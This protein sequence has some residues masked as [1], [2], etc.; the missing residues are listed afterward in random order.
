MHATESWFRF[1]SAL[2]HGTLHVIVLQLGEEI[3][4]SLVLLNELLELGNVLLIELNL[5]LHILQ[6]GTVAFQ[7]KLASLL[8]PVGFGRLLLQSL[9]HVGRL[10]FVDLLHLTVLV[11]D[12]RDVLLLQNALLTEPFLVLQRLADVGILRFVADSFRFLS[13]LPD[14]LAHLLVFLPERLEL[15]LLPAFLQLME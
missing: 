15:F 12:D 2:K 14:Q 11:P 7:L 13:C 8:S 5:A 9:L 1:G 10:A 6:V 4:D 3:G